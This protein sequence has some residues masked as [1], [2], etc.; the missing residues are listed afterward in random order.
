M[1]AFK[2][3]TPVFFRRLFHEQWQSGRVGGGGGW[4]GVEGGWGWRVG[5]GGGWVGVEGGWGWRVEGDKSEV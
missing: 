4:V 2:G 1:A 3:D 5:G